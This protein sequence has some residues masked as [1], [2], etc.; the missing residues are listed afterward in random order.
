MAENEVKPLNWSPAPEVGYSVMRR[1]DG[2][3][4]YTFMDVSPQTVAH[5]REFALQHMLDSDRR[6]RNLYDLRQLADIPEEAIDLALEVSNDP[7]AR[8]IRVAV[9]VS[10][11]LAKKSIEKLAALTPPGGLD[12]GIFTTIEDAEAWLDRPLTLLV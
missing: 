5:W 12:L 8:N 10:G 2:G 9:V 4:H 7:A 3:M 1:A 6:T 11:D